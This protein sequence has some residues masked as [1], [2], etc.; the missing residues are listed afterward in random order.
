MSHAKTSNEY[1][2]VAVLTPGLLS[3]VLL[4]CLGYWMLFPSDLKTARFFVSRGRIERALGIYDRLLLGRLP[5]DERLALLNEM[6]QLRRFSGDLP[7]YLDVVWDLALEGG[8]GTAVLSDALVISRALSAD[9]AAGRRAA[10]GAALFR[11]LLE[12]RDAYE[13]PSK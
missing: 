2:R 11:R 3:A 8:A 4:F 7:A 13:E 10:R 6:V 1:E 5:A 12:H 9:A